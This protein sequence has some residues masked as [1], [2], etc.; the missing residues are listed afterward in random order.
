MLTFPMNFVSV[1]NASGDHQKTWT[2]ASV[3]AE[4]ACC[5]PIEF[6]GSGGGF[7]PEDLFLQSAINCFVG[8]F[9]VICKLSKVHFASVVVKG[10]LVVDKDETGKI[11]MKAIHLDITV[12]GADRPERIQTLAEKTLRDGY[13][14]NSIKSEV[15]HEL[16][17]K[18]A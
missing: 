11:R 9:K 7:S 3:D 12:T 17:L 8:T 14:L 6:G 18:E 16:T 5:I 13:I 10:H 1:A 4:A 15:T 2:I